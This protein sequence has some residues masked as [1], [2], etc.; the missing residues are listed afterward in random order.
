MPDDNVTLNA[1]ANVPRKWPTPIVLPLVFDKSISLLEK[2]DYIFKRFNELIDYINNLEELS[3]EY[4]DQQIELLRVFLLNEIQKLQ[5]FLDSLEDKVDGIEINIDIAFKRML[6]QL[7]NLVKKELFLQDIEVDSKL[8]TWYNRIVEMIH[9]GFTVIDPTTGY[10]STIQVALNNIYYKLIVQDAMT[11]AEYR[12]LQQT[13]LAWRDRYLTVYDYRFRIK[14]LLWQYFS[15]LFDPFTGY[16]T[17]DQ[18][19]FNK[20][21]N[22]HMGG[23]TVDA[24]QALNLTVEQ[25]AALNLTVDQYEQGGWQ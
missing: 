1:L 16:R 8:N 4:T 10:T 9:Y 12:S 23:P 5:D 13:V 2:I 7:L 17:L 22:F 3:H 11:V 14:K 24:Y 19:L 25:Y 21:A 18:L 15:Q 6:D 20:L